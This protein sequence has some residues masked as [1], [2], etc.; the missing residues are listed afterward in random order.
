MT[1]RVLGEVLALAC[2]AAAFAAAVANPPS[3]IFPLGFPFAIMLVAYVGL[4][5][6]A[7]SPLRAMNLPVQVTDENESR[8]RPAVVKMLTWQKACCVATFAWIAILNVLRGGSWWEI[9]LLAAF[10]VS[11]FIVLAVYLPAIRQAAKGPGA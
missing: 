8:L 7:L 2:I 1:Q 6:V 5:I 4:T 11:P 3:H 10:G 9:A